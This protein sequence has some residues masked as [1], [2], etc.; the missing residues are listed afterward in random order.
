MKYLIAI[1]LAATSA[2]A[3]A[4]NLEAL[5]KCFKSLEALPSESDIVTI[6]ANGALSIAGKDGGHRGLF[7]Y[8]G[9]QAYFCAFPSTTDGSSDQFNY[10]NMKIALPQAAPAYITYSSAKSGRFSD[11]GFAETSPSTTPGSPKFRPANCR[12]DTT[13][14][15]ESVFADT[16]NAEIL[17]L[18]REKKSLEDELQ[19][20]AH[21]SV[22]RDRHEKDDGKQ[23]EGASEVP[24]KI[25]SS[26]RYREA[27]D[28]CG[29]LPAVRESVQQVSRQF[30]GNATT[31]GASGHRAN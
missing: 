14:Q 18:P 9:R 11:D 12:A 25:P 2:R 13:A 22:H 24:I 21:R 20:R 1:V 10:Y 28:G 15:T 17:S 6:D 16:L 26:Q 29:G 7:I 3:Y 31:E 4:N 27:L 8:R 23:D 5:E 30:V 19:R